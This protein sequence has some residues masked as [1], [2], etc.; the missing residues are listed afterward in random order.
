MADIKTMTRVFRDSHGSFRYV[1]LP[2]IASLAEIYGK[3]V[4]HARHIE[5]VRRRGGESYDL[6]HAIRIF[7]QH[8]S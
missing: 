4:E 8:T 7:Q 6:E 1:S 5:A 3:Q 2:Y